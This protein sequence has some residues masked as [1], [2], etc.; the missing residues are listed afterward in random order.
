MRYPGTC[1]ERQFSAQ[2]LEEFS[3]NGRVPAWR[4][5]TLPGLVEFDDLCAGKQRIDVHGTVGDFVIA[6]APD[7]PAYQLAVV[8]DDIAMG[9]NEVVRGDDLIPSTA[10]QILLYAALESGNKIPRYGHVP[11][12]VGAD[13]KRTAKRSGQARIADYRASGIAPEKIIGVLARWSGL[14]CS[15]YAMPPDLVEQWSWQRV[16]RQRMILSDELLAELH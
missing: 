15:G 2:Q 3:R 12:V 8:A 5:K 10:R 11:L 16:A 1:R 9:V 4:L 6:K 14:E 7:N 13:G